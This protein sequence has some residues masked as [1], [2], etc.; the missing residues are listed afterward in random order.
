MAIR[1]K[2]VGIKGFEGED[3]LSVIAIPF[4]TAAAWVT[5]SIYYHGTNVEANVTND[6]KLMFIVSRMA[7]ANAIKI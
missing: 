1:L 5:Y 3:Y 4:W 7:L 2:T 6:G